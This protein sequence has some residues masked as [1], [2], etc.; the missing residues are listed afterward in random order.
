M[1]R[2][3]LVTLLL[4]LSVV[5]S[6]CGIIGGGDETATE[7]PDA[8]AQESPE[9]GQTSVPAEPTERRLPVVIAVQNIPR[10]TVITPDRVEI[11][12]YPISAI[13]DDNYQEI[14]YLHGV[15]I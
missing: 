8:V 11:V 4:I 5:L 2:N 10:G 3:V 13:P 1:K 6:A 12:L 14:E 7:D 15:Y 9:P